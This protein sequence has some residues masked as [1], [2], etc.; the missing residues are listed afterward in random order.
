VLLVKGGDIASKGEG[1]DYSNSPNKSVKVLGL[2][3]LQ[4]D[5]S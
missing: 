1:G 3:F 2:D 4:L 5:H